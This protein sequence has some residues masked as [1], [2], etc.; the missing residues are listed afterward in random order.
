M[1]IKLPAWIEGFIFKKI[2]IVLT[3][4]QWMKIKIII[5]IVIKYG[6]S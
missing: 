1:K 4:K 6:Y 3:K 5:I 2:L